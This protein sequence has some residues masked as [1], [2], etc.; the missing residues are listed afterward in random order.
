MG[1]EGAGDGKK[2]VRFDS[3]FLQT[4]KIVILENIHIL[5]AMAFILAHVASSPPLPPPS[6][7]PLMFYGIKWMMENKLKYFC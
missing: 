1:N 7:P 6:L 3:L 2:G 4:H 5:Y